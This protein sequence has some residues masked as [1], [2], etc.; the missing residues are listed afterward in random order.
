MGKIPQVSTC[1]IAWCRHFYLLLFFF[2]VQLQH[3]LSG[4]ISVLDWL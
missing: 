1:I 4:F 2:L 3:D